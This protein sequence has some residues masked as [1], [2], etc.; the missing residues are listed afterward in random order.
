MQYQE[1]LRFGDVCNRNMF[2]E[3]VSTRIY[4]EQSLLQ[5][6]FL[7]EVCISARAHLSEQQA[8]VMLCSYVK[9]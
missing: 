9:Q 5:L 3:N 6:C 4:N 8:P 2:Q 7:Q 1:L